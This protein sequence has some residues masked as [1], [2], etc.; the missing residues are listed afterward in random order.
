MLIKLIKYLP[1]IFCLCVFAKSMDDEII[2]NIEFFTMLE[3][4]EE[5]EK[6]EIDFED[7]NYIAEDGTIK[8][9]RNIKDYQDEK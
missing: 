2:E 9:Q 6:G 8:V 3:Y 5:E 4:L 1:L 7:M